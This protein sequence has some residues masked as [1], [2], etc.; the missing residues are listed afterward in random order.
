MLRLDNLGRQGLLERQA[1]Q[2]TRVHQAVKVR[3]AAKALEAAKVLPALQ[4][5]RAPRAILKEETM[6]EASGQC[7]ERVRKVPTTT[8][9]GE[10]MT[11]GTH[12]QG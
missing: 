8:D 11:E 2:A 1:R 3:Q 7:V 6:E 4:A 9:E 10:E 5:A 12:R